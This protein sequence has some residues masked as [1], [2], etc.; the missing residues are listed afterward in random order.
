MVISILYVIELSIDVILLA[1]IEGKTD[2]YLEVFV[3][4]ERIISDNFDAVL[5]C[6]TSGTSIHHT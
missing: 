4:C 6:L 3:A 5:Y 1:F 2:V